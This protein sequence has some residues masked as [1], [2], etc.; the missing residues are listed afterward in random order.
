[1]LGISSIVARCCIFVSFL[2]FLLNEVMS[3]FTHESVMKSYLW[4][5]A[6]KIILVCLLTAI[7]FVIWW[8]A[9]EEL[10][11][12]M[13]FAPPQNTITSFFVRLLTSFSTNFVKILVPA[14]GFTIPWTS[15]LPVIIDLTFVAQF[16]RCLSPIISILWSFSLGD[17]LVQFLTCLALMSFIL[18]PFFTDI[19][20]PTTVGMVFVLHDSTGSCVWWCRIPAG[21]VLSAACC[22]VFPE[23]TSDHFRLYD[24]FC[25]TVLN[26]FR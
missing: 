4:G 23:T 26:P 9:F 19:Q 22:L 2:N 17:A 10:F 20:I 25:L 1:M 11:L 18:L 14:P 8:R 21:G 7:K 24:L 12:P 16:L 3:L 13:S 5:A 15:K 6:I